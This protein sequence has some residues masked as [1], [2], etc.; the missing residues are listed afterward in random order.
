[1]HTLEKKTNEEVLSKILE[2]RITGNEITKRQLHFVGHIK[3]EWVG[4]YMLG[5]QD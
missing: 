1:M 2:K 4:E 5:G 3:R